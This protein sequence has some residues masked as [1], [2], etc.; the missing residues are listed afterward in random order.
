MTPTETP[1][2]TNMSNTETI[3][4]PRPPLQEEDHNAPY[5][6]D[7]TPFSHVVYVLLAIVLSCILV[8][9]ALI[10]A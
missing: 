9:A 8:A 5:L 3:S 4:S 6:H 7:T 1:A 2:S 10:M